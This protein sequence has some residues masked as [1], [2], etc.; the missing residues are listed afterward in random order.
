MRLRFGIKHSYGIFPN[1]GVYARNLN[2]ADVPKVEKVRVFLM[3][4]LKQV[5][6]F[7]PD[8]TLTES[9]F[10]LRK[11]EFIFTISPQ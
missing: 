1:A 11:F 4:G 10:K 5:A 7:V 3:D 8:M 2:A 6:D 9:G